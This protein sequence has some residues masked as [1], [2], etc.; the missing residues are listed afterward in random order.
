MNR[1]CNHARHDYHDVITCWFPYYKIPVSRR[2]SIPTF[3]QYH[4]PSSFPSLVRSLSVGGSR[5]LPVSRRRYDRPTGQL[6][7][8]GWCAGWS[9]PGCRALARVVNKD[10]ALLYDPFIAK[11]PEEVTMRWT[12]DPTAPDLDLY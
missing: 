12:V 7:C 3:P 4:E 9:M 10:L 11:T 2:S 5:R 6:V 1:E 8:F